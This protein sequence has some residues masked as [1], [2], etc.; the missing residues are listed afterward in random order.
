M[1]SFL[2]PDMEATSILQTANKLKIP[3]GFIPQGDFIFPVHINNPLAKEIKLSLTVFSNGIMVQETSLDFSNS[4]YC[5]DFCFTINNPLGSIDTYI[6]AIFEK[7]SSVKIH[8]PVSPRK[9]TSFHPHQSDWHEEE[10]LINTEIT[11]WENDSIQTLSNTTSTNK[12][13]EATAMNKR[14]IES[15]VQ[16]RYFRG[17]LSLE[18]AQKQMDFVIEHRLFSAGNEKGFKKWKLAFYRKV[19]RFLYKLITRN[20]RRKIYLAKL[21]RNYVNNNLIAENLH[22]E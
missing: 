7:T 18:D 12:L 22:G 3:L 1:E 17:L 6:E 8:F 4:N 20:S 13:N 14:Q 19:T 11:E 16:M 15:F 9:R 10:E 21:Y 5:C 2:L